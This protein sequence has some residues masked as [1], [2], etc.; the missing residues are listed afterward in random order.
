MREM[1]RKDRQIT[2]KE[3]MLEVIKA[4]NVLHL[5][6]VNGEE[7]YVI[8]MNYGYTWEGEELVFY[9]HSALEGMKF[10]LLEK[11]NRLC[12]AV[13]CDHRLVEGKV[14]CQY[15]YEF[16]SVVGNGRGEIITDP[17]E[18]I[19]A[20]QIIME[21]VSGK[22][23]EFTEKLLSIVTLWRMRVEGFQGKRRK[24]PKPQ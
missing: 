20:M 13:D 9:F 22:E 19:K 8:P 18:R 10:E 3:E 11:N 1:R 4:C 15:S 21:H 17:Q 14:P 7:P 2:D 23:F 16:S 5:A 6:M 12:F 24:L